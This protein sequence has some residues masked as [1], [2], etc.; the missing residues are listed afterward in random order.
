MGCFLVSPLRAALIGTVTEASG[1][2]VSGAHVRLEFG[3]EEAVTDAQGH[4]RLVVGKQPVIRGTD[5]LDMAGARIAFLGA[6]AGTSADLLTVSQKGYLTSLD[7]VSGPDATLSISL[8]ASAG[9]VTDVDGN[10]YQ[11]VRLGD[12]VWTV[13]NLRTRHFNDGSPIPFDPATA[14][15][16]DNTT[17][18]YCLP[19]NTTNAAIIRRFGALYNFYAVETGK[20]APKGW[21]VPSGEEWKTFERYLISNGYNHDGSTTGDKIAAAISARITW[22]SSTVDGAIGNR[23]SQNNRSGFAALGTGFRHESGIFE[24]FG[25]YTGWWTS[26]PA[27]HDHAGMIDLHFNEDKWSNAHHY[28][29]ACAYPVRLIRDSK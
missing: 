22:T 5:S 23:L 19:R 2:P 13:E 6:Q 10:T 4:F 16:K 21:H 11:A 3:G 29:S 9:S 20:L 26:T 7:P 14:T 15:W 8:I 28:R 12:Q 17:P 1:K 25:R 18:K 24:P 27:S